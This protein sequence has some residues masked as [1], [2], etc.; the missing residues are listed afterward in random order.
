MRRKIVRTATEN[1]GFE[2]R[3]LGLSGILRVK[4]DADLLIPCIMS[5]IDALDELIAVYN[6]CTDNSAE[7]LYKMAALYPGKIKVY[8]YPYKVLSNFESLEDFDKANSLPDDSPHL[9]CNYYNFAL[10]KTTYKYAVKIDADQ[11]YFTDVLKEWGNCCR[12]QTPQRI[13]ATYRIGQIVNSLFKVHKYLGFKMGC[14]TIIPQLISH[15]LYG[16]YKSYV[17][18]LFLNGEDVCLSL[19]G[20]NVFYKEKWTVSIGKAGKNVN[21]L[22]PF[23]GEG[24]HLIFKVTDK[25]FYT[26]YNMPYY[27]IVNNR[28]YTL[29]EQFVHPYRT[30]CAGFCWFHLNEMR[31]I[32][33]ARIIESYDDFKECFEPLDNIAG[34]RFRDILRR[35]DK[36]VFT[37]RQRTLF[38]FIFEMDKESVARNAGLLRKCL[39][40]D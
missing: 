26:K 2:R 33:R 12:E 38:G 37:N 35:A 8:E 22:P 6:D 29:I 28:K 23:N 36:T 7:I 10:A 11:L 39:S 15:K 34:M 17:K 32:T 19:S 1:P 14:V 40:Y 24:D 31:P 21:L 4:D 13:D 25:T 16:C 20:V 27:G 18:T 5:C 9:L 3:P 30:L